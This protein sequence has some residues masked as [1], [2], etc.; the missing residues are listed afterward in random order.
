[1][2]VLHDRIMCRMASR[3]GLEDNIAWLLREETI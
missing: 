1:M 2:G 3:E